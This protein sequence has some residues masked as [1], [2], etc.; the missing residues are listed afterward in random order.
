MLA[1]SSDSDALI[2]IGQSL[3]VQTDYSPF[4]QLWNW[5]SQTRTRLLQADAQVSAVGLYDGQVYG[6]R[7]DGSVVRW[8][9]QDGKA[10]VVQ[11]ADWIRGAVT[12]LKAS[13][14]GAFAVTSGKTVQLWQKGA[15]PRILTGAEEDV[16]SVAFEP[17]PDSDVLWASAGLNAKRYDLNR[18]DARTELAADFVDG[19]DMSADGSRLVGSSGASGPGRFRVWNTSTGQ[20]TDIMAPTE[21]Y[22]VAMF[23]AGDRFVAGWPD[24]T[25]RAYRVSDGQVVWT[26]KAADRVDSLAVSADAT[27]IVSGGGGFKKEASFDL[28]DASNGKRIGSSPGAGLAVLSSGGTTVATEGYTWMQVRGTPDPPFFRIL[29]LA[30]FRGIREAPRRR[31]AMKAM[32]LDAR[33]R[34]L[35]TVADAIE[36]WDLTGSPRVVQQ[37]SL[38][39]K[40]PTDVAFSPDGSRLLACLEGSLTVWDLDNGILLLRFYEDGSHYYAKARWRAGKIFAVDRGHVTILDPSMEGLEDWE[41]AARLNALFESAKRHTE[42]AANTKSER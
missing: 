5:Q 42:A 25:M 23:P 29:S 40:F 21:I 16:T 2:V 39:G 19:M 10:Q 6:G 41:K 38:Q 35:A 13:P 34:R 3:Y 28:W 26:A 31:Q 9:L 11:L 27:R 22:S 17:R 36:I 30:D 7:D 20:S 24:G 18:R 15:A 32:A 12:G 4:A 1:F 8:N 14:H 33:G 37:I